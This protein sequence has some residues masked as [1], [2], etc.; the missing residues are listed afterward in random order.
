MNSSG[1]IG[2][3]HLATREKGE[4]L[5]AFMCQ[6]VKTQLNSLED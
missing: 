1:I 3:A 5:T 4:K 6:N 2:G